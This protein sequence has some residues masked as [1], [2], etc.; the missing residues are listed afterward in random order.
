MDMKKKNEEN[1]R[2]YGMA[3]MPVRGVKET[4]YDPDIRGRHVGDKALTLIG[5][6]VLV[7]LA[8]LGIS[9]EL[10]ITDTAPL[11]PGEYATSPLSLLRTADGLA[12]LRVVDVGIDNKNIEVPAPAAGANPAVATVPAGKRWTSIDTVFFT[13]VTSVVVANRVVVLEIYDNNGNLCYQTAQGAQTAG[14]T[15]S[16]TYSNYAYATTTGNARFT[17]IPLVSL[18]PGWYVKVSAVLIDV[19][20]QFSAVD[21]MVREADAY[22]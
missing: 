13:L 15:V 10:D 9:E 2:E 16:Y 14:T 20:D 21:L 22:L 8:K 17:S 5:R 18:P 6:R 7:G 12:N 4:P 3:P 19:A 11:P 1:W